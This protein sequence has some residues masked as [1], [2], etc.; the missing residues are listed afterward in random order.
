[1]KKEKPHAEAHD[2]SYQKIL[3]QVPAQ[4]STIR[5]GLRGAKMKKLDSDCQA[6]SKPEKKVRESKMLSPVLPET[7]FLRLPEVL[8][9]FPVSRSAW[10]RGVKAGI[11]PA[12]VPLGPRTAAWRVEDIRALIER[13]GATRDNP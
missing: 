12:P 6:D 13:T 10:Y 1:M 7:G 5:A 2:S 9:F 3:Y 8:R 4:E 11:Y